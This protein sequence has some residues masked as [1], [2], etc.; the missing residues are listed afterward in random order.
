MYRDL[1]KPL[2]FMSLRVYKV[3]VLAV[4]LYEP[5]KLVYTV[6]TKTQVPI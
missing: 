5:L 4:G 2:L 6:K 3:A 1:H